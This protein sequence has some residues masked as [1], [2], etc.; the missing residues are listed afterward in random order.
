METAPW[1]QKDAQRGLGNTTHGIPAM[2]VAGWVSV[3]S[4]FGFLSTRQYTSL[5]QTSSCGHQMY[6]FC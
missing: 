4:P 6:S 1:Y 5:L 3:L 2:S